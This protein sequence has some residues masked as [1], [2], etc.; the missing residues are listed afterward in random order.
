MEQWLVQPHIGV[1]PFRLDMSRQEFDRVFAE[2]PREISSRNP[3]RPKRLIF[4]RWG[5]HVTL[6]RDEQA[7]EIG[8]GPESEVAF[9]FD[10]VDLLRSPANRALAAVRA[11]A[12][13]NTSHPEVGSLFIFPKLDMTLWRGYTPTGPNDR[14]PEGLH[15]RAATIAR[16]G[17]YARFLDLGSTQP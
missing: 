9:V 17:V 10:G 8:M 11:R 13:Y 14:T 3:D 5:V 1:G 16:K 7:E 15:F 12:P 6:N 2:P 4:G